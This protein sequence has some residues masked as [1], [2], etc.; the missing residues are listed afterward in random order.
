[1]QLLQG[2]VLEQR[3]RLAICAGLSCQLLYAL[4]QGWALIGLGCLKHLLQQPHAP[5][6]VGML[7]RQDSQ[8]VAAFLQCN[9]GSLHEYGL[10]CQ[11]ISQSW[12]DVHGVQHLVSIPLSF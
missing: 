6:P 11:C 2:Q 8:S 3:A 12:C 4:G 7:H 1:M 10:P 5:G 9:Y